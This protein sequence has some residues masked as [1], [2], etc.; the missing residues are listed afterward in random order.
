[1]KDLS[2]SIKDGKSSLITKVAMSRNGT[3]LLSIQND[4]GKCLNSCYRDA[5]WIWHLQF[6]QLNFRGLSL[7]AKQNMVR[8]LP[9][10]NHQ[11]QLWERCLLRKQFQMSFP[12]ELNSR[13][14]KSLEIIH[15]D[16][17]GSISLDKNIYFLIFIDD[18]SRKTWVYFFKHKLEVFTTFKKFKVIVEKESCQWIKVVRTDRVWEFTPKEFQEFYGENGISCPLTFPRSP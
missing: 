6:V 14:K 3:F 18:F 8:V 5:L 15:D 1:M 2:I 13:A 16:V 17:C 7:M 11:Y 12:K 4:V 10:I 9:L